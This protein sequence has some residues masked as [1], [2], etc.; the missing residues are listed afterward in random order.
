MWNNL[1]IR[2]ISCTSKLRSRLIKFRYGIR[3]DHQTGQVT[4]PQSPP[5]PIQ[6]PP[7][8][9]I[10][11]FQIPQKW[12]RKQLDDNEIAVINNGGPL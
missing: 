1:T 4:T 12:R 7:G 8:E 5:S 11:D 3:N 10:W 6:M 9:A 2:S